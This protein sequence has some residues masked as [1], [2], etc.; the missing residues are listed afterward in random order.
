M[1]DKR[2]LSILTQGVRGGKDHVSNENSA[3]KVEIEILNRSV[4]EV[5]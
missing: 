4:Q 1:I 5:F 3:E 2:F